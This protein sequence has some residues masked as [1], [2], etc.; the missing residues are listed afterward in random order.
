MADDTD[1]LIVGAGAAG[2]AAARELS[3][4][5]FN[6]VV[7]EAR[8]RIGG[9][10]HTHLDPRAGAPIELGA[11]FVHGKPPE[12]LKLAEREHFQLIELP[13]THWYFR[14]AVLS[15]SNEFWSKIEAAMNE[16]AK[17]KGPDE[18]FAEFLDEYS[19]KHQVEDIREMA[20][21]YVEGFHAAHD[22][23]ISVAGL[24]KTNEAAAEI[25]DEK[26]FR[27]ASG[28]LAMAQALEAEAIAHGASFRL[29]TVVREVAWRAGAV[30]VTATNGEQF[31]ARRL[32][33]T[34]PLGVLQRNDVSFTPELP[35][36]EEAARKLAVGQVSKV[37]LRFREP[38]WEQLKLPAS[39]GKTASLNDLVF[40]HAPDELP[41]TWWTQLPVRAPLLVGW[42][43]GPRAELLIS[44]SQDAL[45]D[46]SLQALSHIFAVPPQF[47][48]EALVDFYTHNWATDPFSLG[49]YSYIPVGALHAQAALAE[50]VEDTIYF[51]GEAVNDE[52][53]HGTVHGALSSGLR[54]ARMIYQ[55][56]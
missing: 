21:L 1:I 35:A 27:P 23:R 19:G 39:E 26:Q 14:N 44:E 37:M 45:R 25:D 48:E 2:L 43:G 54:A 42:A 51:A 24:N 46:Q 32:I 55:L 8:D 22:D 34:L 29:N 41:P 50:P 15:K 33:V 38:F 7:L 49:A 10:I 31:K 9:R 6:V 11:E 18:S 16:M 53:H 12:T 3:A 4:A 36:K 56:P 52:G 28:Y 5:N 30:T 47:L 40:I 20:A 17:H 13:N